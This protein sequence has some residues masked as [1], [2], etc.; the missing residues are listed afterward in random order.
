MLAPPPGVRYIR[1]WRVGRLGKH[2]INIPG[3]EPELTQ[4][5]T[6]KG[7]EEA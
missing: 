2:I 7:H 4:E 6:M 3:N 5:A 1:E